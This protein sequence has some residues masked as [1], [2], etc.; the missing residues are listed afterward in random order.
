MSTH[1]PVRVIDVRLDAEPEVLRASRKL[2]AAA[3]RAMGAS[4][5]AAFDLE[6]A[7]GE[8][9]ANAY[10]HAYGSAGRG[11][12]RIRLAF[13][14]AGLIATVTDMGARLRSRPRIPRQVP[15]RN[16]RGRG[17]FLMS[18]LM[19]DLEVIHPVQ[20]GRGTA[21]RMTKRLRPRW[22]PAERPSATRSSDR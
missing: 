12:I 15:L 19:D 16:R 11:R 13:D 17:L 10:D 8:A 22:P 1:N 5:V 4:R 6:I 21:V 3:A 2:V 18:R 14:G 7:L 20:D 9:L